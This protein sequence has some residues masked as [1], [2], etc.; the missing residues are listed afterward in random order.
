MSFDV[1]VQDLPKDIATM[2]DIRRDFRPGP[3]GSRAD[4]IGGILRAAPHTDFTDPTWGQIGGPKLQ[5]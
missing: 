1:F 2:Y 3:I 5:H 4:I